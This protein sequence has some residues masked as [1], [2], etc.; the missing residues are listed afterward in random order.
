MNRTVLM[1]V[2]GLALG[3]ALTG[4]A[5]AQQA[6]RPGGYRHG[7]FQGGAWR[8][9]GFPGADSGAVLRPQ[10]AAQLAAAAMRANCLQGYRTCVV[11]R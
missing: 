5:A 10:E 9:G 7:A 3:A 11:P 6:G 4:E 8:G 1:L 2:A